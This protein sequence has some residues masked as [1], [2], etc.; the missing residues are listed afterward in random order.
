MNRPSSWSARVVFPTTITN[1]AAAIPSPRPADDSSLTIT[2]T[3][4]LRI[5]S[6]TNACPSS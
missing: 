5:A 2:P 3:A 1:G 6:D 4:P